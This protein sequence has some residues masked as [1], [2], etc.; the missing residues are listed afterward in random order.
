MAVLG[1]NHPLREIFSILLL[2]F[3]TEDS[4]WRFY[5]NFMPI[6]PVTKKN[7]FIVPVTNTQHP[8]FRRHFAPLW[9]TAS[10]SYSLHFFT[11]S[12]SSFQF[13]A[14]VHTIAT[15]FAVVSIL[16][17]LFLIFLSTPYLELSFILTLH[18]HLTILIS[19]RWSA[20]SFSFLTAA[21]CLVT[22]KDRTSVKKFISLHADKPDE[23]PWKFS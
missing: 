14:H 20:T 10:T 19:A 3:N 16:H 11:K 8:P 23:Q 1:Q 7:K 17:H 12:V 2:R 5:R 6:C 22:Y 13:T 18:I 21:W 4:D 15:C 9:R